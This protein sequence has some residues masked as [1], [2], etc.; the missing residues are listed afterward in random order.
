VAAARGCACGTE[1]IVGVCVPVDP[2]AFIDD[3]DDVI[4]RMEEAT[5]DVFS[6]DGEVFGLHTDG[7]AAKVALKAWARTHIKPLVPWYPDE[8]SEEAIDEGGAA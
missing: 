8:A 4:E 6:S 3:I 2:G 7:E 1:K 5:F